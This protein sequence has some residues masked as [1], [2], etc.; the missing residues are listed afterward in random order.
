MLVSGI[1][2]KI[3]IPIFIGLIVVFSAFASNAY[4]ATCSFAGMDYSESN[5]H[6]E[7]MVNRLEGMNCDGVYMHDWEAWH[8]D[9]PLNT[10]WLF[11]HTCRSCPPGY[12]LENAVLHFDEG[13]EL[14][15][16]ICVLDNPCDITV[17]DCREW[18]PDMYYD[19]QPAGQGDN[20]YVIEGRATPYITDPMTAHCDCGVLTEYRC[21]SGYW[22]RPTNTTSGCTKCLSMRNHVD[23]TDVPG[24]SSAGSTSITQCYMRAN[25]RLRDNTGIFQFTQPCYY[26]N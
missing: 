15:Y 11:I 16:K 6:D 13:C 9:G 1:I 25:V 23:T 22:G 10:D 20:L 4:G 24:L 12:V 26:T 19:W 7:W 18:Y 8:Y 21:A 2:S 5:P 3:N 14:E 17:D